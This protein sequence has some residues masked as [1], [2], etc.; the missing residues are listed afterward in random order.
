MAQFIQLLLVSPPMKMILQQ[1]CQSDQFYEE[2][3]FFSVLLQFFGGN[4]QQFLFKCA[5][6]GLERLHKNKI[7]TKHIATF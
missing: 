6:T 7:F 1:E 3:I 2:L 5:E 4:L